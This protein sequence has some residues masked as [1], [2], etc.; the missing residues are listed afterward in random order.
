MKSC[1]SK[2]RLLHH[3]VPVAIESFG[4]IENNNTFKKIQARIED[5]QT[6]LPGYKSVVTKLTPEYALQLQE[7][8]QQKAKWE[9]M[10][11]GID[12]WK[13]KYLYPFGDINSSANDKDEVKH[14]T[15]PSVKSNLR[16]QSLAQ[17]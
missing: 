2:V 17:S 6:R 10:N 15:L 13:K 5:M 16:S 1:G 8:E 14:Q 4:I 12:Q 7:E 11:M 9:S 3:T